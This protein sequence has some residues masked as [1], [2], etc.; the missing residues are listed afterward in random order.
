M[1]RIKRIFFACSDPKK[2]STNSCRAEIYGG[3]MQDEAKGLL[4]GFFQKL[5]DQ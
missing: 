2:N 4:Q 5:R 1:V 3:M